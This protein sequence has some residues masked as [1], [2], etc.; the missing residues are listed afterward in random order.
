[1]RKAVFIHNPKISTVSAIRQNAHIC[2]LSEFAFSFVI[3]YNEPII[4][5]EGENVDVRYK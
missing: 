4:F 5:R 1:M 3:L 2:V